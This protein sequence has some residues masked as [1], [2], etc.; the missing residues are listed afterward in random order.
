GTGVVKLTVASGCEWAASASESWVTLPEGITGSGSREIK[1]NVAANTGAERRATIKVGGRYFSILQETACSYLVVDSTDVIYV[2]ASGKF[3]TI[4]VT[5]GPGCPWNT[6]ASDAWVG[7]SHNEVLPDGG[8]AVFNV[9]TNEGPYRTAQVQVAGKTIEFRQ[10]AGNLTAVSSASYGST[11]APGSIASV[12]GQELTSQI[13][14]AQALPLPKVLAGAMVKV[15]VIGYG[16]FEAPLFYVSP[17]QINFQVPENLPLGTTLIEVHSDKEFFSRGVLRVESVAPSLFSANSDGKDVAVAQVLRIK[18]DGRE[19]YEPV[20]RYDSVQKRFVPAPI[21]LGETSD[22][23]YLLLYGT[24]IRGRS[25]L[26]N[27]DVKL[28][29]ESVEVLY[30]GA[31]GGFEGLDQVNVRLTRALIGRG[32]VDVVLS[33]DGKS[34]NRLRVSFK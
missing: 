7:Y 17:G 15:V 34:A 33:A 19:L 31:Q 25:S 3:V 28:G 27:V 8:Y 12:F 11:I 16:G 6:V 26:S 10:A 4:R 1:F 5:T 32:E 22:Q 20:A 30:A 21:D 23:V 14:L 29:G 9:R 18:A 2:S 24:G 13:G